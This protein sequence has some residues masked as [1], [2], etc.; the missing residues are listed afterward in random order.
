MS[1]EA[2]RGDGRCRTH[3]APR[4]SRSIRRR[5]PLPP[6]L[7]A[8]RADDGVR[9]FVVPASRNA[10][11]ETTMTKL[12]SRPF[13]AT[14]ADEFMAGRPPARRGRGCVG[15]RGGIACRSGVVG[16]PHLREPADRGTAPT[17]G[18]DPGSRRSLCAQR[19]FVSVASCQAASLGRLRGRDAGGC[20]AQ[21]YA[22]TTWTLN[23][24]LVRA[25]AAPHQ[26]PAHGQHATHDKERRRSDGD[27][28]DGRRAQANDTRCLL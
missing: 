22:P 2:N 8:E 21:D 18:T 28:S 4:G 10:M 7:R 15:V 1:E 24:P 20:E 25:P 14:P 6:A 13:P 11:G 5:G 17:A 9:A 12:W 19:G 26:Q 3:T 23:S 16:A 27:T